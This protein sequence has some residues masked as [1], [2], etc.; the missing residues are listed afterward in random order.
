MKPLVHL[1]VLVFLTLAFNAQATDYRIRHLEPESWWVGMRE[2]QLQLMVH[3][4]RIADLTPSLSYPGV[5]LKDVIRVVNQNYLFIDLEI[6]DAAPAGELVLQ[7]K[8]QNETVLSYRY[9][10]NARPD[11]SAQR[12]GFNSSDAIYLI[13]PD[14]FANGNPDNDSL[15]GLKEKADRRNS[16]GRHGGDLQ[17]I[18][19]HLDYI[20]KMGFTQIWPTPLMENDQPRTSYHGYAATNLYQVDARFSS[21]QDYR[22]LVAKAKAKN[23]GFIQDVVLNHIGSGHWWMKDLPTADWLN[24]QDQPVITNH[25]RTTLQDPHAAAVDRQKF[26]DGWFTPEMPDLNQRNPLLANYLIQNS[27]W[28]IEYAGLSGL[29]TDTYSYSD[30]AFLT[31]WS[32]RIMKEYPS[33]N[34]V[35]EEWSSNP[36]IVSYWQRGKVNPDHYL[37]S[38]PSMMDFPVFE[39]LRQGLLSDD[40]DGSGFDKLY[41]AIANDFLYPDAGNLVIFEGNHDTSRI[42]S[43]LGQDYRLYQMAMV[44]LATM[45]GIPQFF[46]GTEILMASPRQRD[47]GKVRADFP[48]GWPG[49]AVDAFSGRG[50]GP[51]QKAAQA[52]LRRLL[53]W[54]KTASVVHHGKL[55]HFAPEHGSYV[56]FRYQEDKK[57]MVAFNKNLTPITL[58]TSR[59]REML[60]PQASATDVLSGRRLSLAKSLTLAPRS[61]LLLEVDR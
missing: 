50:L 52:F 49:D 45:R 24:F 38:T 48:G 35:G 46:Y 55:M 5:T 4:E 17:G 34:I 1:L 37:S 18:G 30:P 44:Y 26:S 29:R 23:L 57:V 60:T 32:A 59:F 36:A 28:W 2:G 19:E 25:K 27:L 20:A 22:N 54:R 16:S 53:N 42:F 43:E 14:R 21:N 56:Y 51:R 31:R 39:A 6:G 7:F 15:A 33:F 13:S 40:K 8:Q 58:D 10:L 61:V 11:H 3:G 47:D 12:Q 9:R 41:L